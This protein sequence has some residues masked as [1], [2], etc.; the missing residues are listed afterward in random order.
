MRED[1]D[2]GSIVYPMAWCDDV[3]EDRVGCT[4]DGR[5]RRRH[6]LAESVEARRS[7]ARGSGFF[8]SGFRAICINVE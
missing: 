4:E 7:P 2:A 1:G 3:G 6:E 8:A 5:D